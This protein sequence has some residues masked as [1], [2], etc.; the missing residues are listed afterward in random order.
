MS[1]STGGR[2]TAGRPESWLSARGNGAAA[3]VEPCRESRSRGTAAT[4]PDPGQPDSNQAIRRAEPGSAYRSPVHGDLVTQGEVLEGEL[5]VA[6]AEDG[7]EP[8]KVEQEGDH[9]TEIVSGS[10]LRDQQ[11]THWPAFCEG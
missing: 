7:E 2:P 9:R 4:R 3:N 6:G 10:G 1:A 8:E 11:P 5:A